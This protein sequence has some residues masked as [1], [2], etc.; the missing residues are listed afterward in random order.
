MAGRRRPTARYGTF[1]FDQV[2]DAVIP[3]PTRGLGVCALALNKGRIDQ[4]PPGRTHPQACRRG[5]RG[6]FGN[7]ARAPPK[8]RWSQPRS[9]FRCGCTADTDGHPV[10]NG[11]PIGRCGLRRP[12]RSSP[13]SVMATQ[14]LV[15]PAGKVR[16]NI[17]PV[18]VPAGVSYRHHGSRWKHHCDGNILSC[19]LVW[20]CPD[21][22]HE[23]HP[24][25]SL[26]LGRAL[27]AVRCELRQCLPAARC[28]GPPP[29]GEV[30]ARGDL[31][32][33]ISRF[34]KV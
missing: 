12:C 18:G 14:V 28:G 34:T 26:L 30:G 31:R 5:C 25:V 16:R 17:E 27:G 1:Y 9:R 13:R 8:H 29:C 7:G 10:P 3:M 24:G 6:L 33:F 22:A 15:A 19:G 21:L 11:C 4:R 2:E 32:K 23:P 20:T